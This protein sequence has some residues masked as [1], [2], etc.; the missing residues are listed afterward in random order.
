MPRKEPERAPDR[1]LRGSEK[2]QGVESGE[3]RK[4]PGGEHARTMPWAR[5][6]HGAAVATRLPRRTRRQHVPGLVVPELFD[7]ITF[8]RARG[9]S[10]PVI[11]SIGFWTE[12]NPDKALSASALKI[13]YEAEVKRRAPTRAAASKLPRSKLR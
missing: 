10:Y 4:R 13:W 11:A 2:S 1:Q 5:S 3:G 12:D 8:F 7:V 9:D 6:V